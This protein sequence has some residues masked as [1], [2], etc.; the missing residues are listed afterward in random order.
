M[1]VQAYN[2]QIENHKELEEF[3]KNIVAQLKI[4]KDERET[5]QKKLAQARYQQTQKTLDADKTLKN[6]NSTAQTVELNRS[7]HQT[8]RKSFYRLKIVKKS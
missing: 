5:L 3:S 2:R 1:F 7:E 4:R 6:L 8:K